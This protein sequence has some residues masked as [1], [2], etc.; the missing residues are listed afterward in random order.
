MLLHR[1]SM[2]LVL[3]A[4]V[5]IIPSCTSK[6][7]SSSSY[8]IEHLR[9]VALRISAQFGERRPM[10]IEVVRTQ[11]SKAALIMLDLSGESTTTHAGLIQLGS[12]HDNVIGERSVYVVSTFG[13]F[14]CS[15]CTTTEPGR[16][17]FG[18]TLTFSVATRTFAPI[19]A[20]IREHAPHLK[21]VGSVHDISA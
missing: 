16:P 2:I 4:A 8:P 20:I 12:N 14:R 5:G 7:S 3:A 13:R 19:Q 17:I 10:R 15:Q 6:D 9:T 1:K 11:A 21:R 18:P